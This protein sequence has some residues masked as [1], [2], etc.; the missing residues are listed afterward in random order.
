MIDYLVIPLPFMFNTA[1][2]ILRLFIGVCFVIHGLGKLGVVGPGNMDGFV[3]WLKSM[4]IPYPDLQARAAMVTEIT[5]GAMITL[6]LLTRL[7]T[8]MCFATMLV[9]VVIGHKGGGYLVTNNPPGF[10]YPLN[11]AAICAVL[12][13]LG[14]GGYSLDALLFL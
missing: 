14:P 9:A 3:G 5:G 4:N 10:E 2:L 13:L 8:V 11:L 6:G 12:F 1:L 7:G